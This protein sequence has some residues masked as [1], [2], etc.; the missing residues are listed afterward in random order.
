MTVELRAAGSGTE[1]SLKHEQFADVEARDKHQ[2][3]WTGCIA[4]LER[5]L[6]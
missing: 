4:R 6:A 2:Q 5:F 1:L 3:G